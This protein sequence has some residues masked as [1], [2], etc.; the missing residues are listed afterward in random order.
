MQQSCFLCTFYTLWT[1]FRG[2][3]G[4]IWVQAAD[5]CANATV[6]LPDFLGLSDDDE[7]EEDAGDRYT[8]KR[9]GQALETATTNRST[10]AAPVKKRRLKPRYAAAKAA[11]EAAA[12]AA[13][14][15]KAKATAPGAPAAA[16][17]AAPAAQATVSST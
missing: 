5:E 2:L 10:T 8:N 13:E 9:S 16:A 3:G 6:S 1:I 4:H 7:E 14:T 15:E 12:A 11:A 17:A